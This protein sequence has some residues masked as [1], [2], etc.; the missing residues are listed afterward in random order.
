VTQG[1]EFE[2]PGGFLGQL[3]GGFAREAVR[4]EIRQTMERQRAAL[5]S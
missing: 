5:E 2:V 3:A 4:R 1:I